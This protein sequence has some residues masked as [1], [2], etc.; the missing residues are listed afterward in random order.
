[1][2]L[3]L[4]KNNSYFHYLHHRYSF[5]I[6]AC[7]GS[8]CREKDSG[9]AGMTTQTHISSG[10]LLINKHGFTLIE[11]F[12]SVAILS[13]VL[14]AIYSTFFLAHRAVDGM[15]ESLVKLQEARR[16]LDILRCELESSFFKEADANTLLQIKDRDSY[17]KSASELTFTTFSVLRPGLSRVSYYIEERGGR[18][19]LFKKIELPQ[20]TQEKREGFELIENLDAFSIEAKYQDE[21]VK[22]WDTDINKNTPEEIRINLAFRLKD[23]TITLSDT[24]KPRI[25]KPI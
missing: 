17:G 3:F 25:N 8:S 22:T 11:V 5:F 14:A 10:D 7:P 23:R 20:Q 2:N 21:W 16:A 24:A 9:Q 12:V 1:M 19:N 13:V 6:P 18:L 15:D 4:S